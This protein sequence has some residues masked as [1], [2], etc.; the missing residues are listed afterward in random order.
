MESYLKALI[1]V[2]APFETILEVGEVAS[3]YIQT[4]HPK[5]HVVIKSEESWETALPKLGVFDAIF[6]GNFKPECEVM[7]KT[8]SLIV[9]QGRALVENTRKQFPQLA[10]LRYSDTDLNEFMVGLGQLS[11]KELSHFL[12]ELK[13][14]Q[15]ISEEQYE[16]MTTK[17]HLEKKEG[18]HS[19]TIEIRVDPILTF[20]NACLE[21]HMRKGSR[22]SWFAPHSMSK[23]ED[24]QF[25]DAIIT[26]PNFEYSEHSTPLVMKLEKMI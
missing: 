4:F 17:Y 26:N 12:H 11:R 21:N 18:S 20:I 2:L 10:T 25:F 3:D 9:Q 15:H 8:G 22:L 23:Y 19:K 14:N 5:Q 7:H 1:D 24:P 6:F 16:I 13:M